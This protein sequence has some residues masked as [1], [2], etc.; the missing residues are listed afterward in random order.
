MYCENNIKNILSVL[1]ELVDGYTPEKE[2]KDYLWSQRQINESK[3][4]ENSKN[5][6]IIKLNNITGEKE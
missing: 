1:I 4:N 6:N 3:T 2:I 5:Y